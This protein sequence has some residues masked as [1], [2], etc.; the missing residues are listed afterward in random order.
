MAKRSVADLPPDIEDLDDYTESINILCH[1]DT[2]AGKTV[3][4][5]RLPNVLILAV[6][7]GAVSAK[8]WERVKPRPKS[9]G[10]IKVWKVPHWDVLVEAY[11]WL[12]DND[13]PFDWVL[14]DSISAA[15]TRCLR[16]IME[17]V[18]KQNKTR[19]PDIPAI[20]DHFKWQLMMKRMVTDFNELP[21][22]IVWLARSMNKE[23]PDGEDI[24][25]PLIEGK[26]YQISAWVC[27]EVHLLCYLK[28]VKKGKGDDHKMVRKLYTNEHPMYWCK[29]RYNILPHVITNPDANK[30]VQ[31]IIES[32]A[33]PLVGKAPVVNKK[34][35][36]AKK[37]AGKSAR[38]KRATSK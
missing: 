20:Q 19:D 26:D 13:H 34:Q 14:I 4:W 33:K 35:P 29:D 5:S 28:K 3:M 11:E 2:G 18:V 9:A 1:A 36:A 21:V 24:V 37:A 15:Q 32:G 30:I 10:I 6:E 22:N 16:G 23:D 25:V 8:R 38:T 17:H 31:A 7:E 27:G 12:R